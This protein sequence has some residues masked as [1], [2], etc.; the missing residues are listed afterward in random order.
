MKSRFYQQTFAGMILVCCSLMAQA[1]D[2]V[3][4][5]T[6]SEYA[7]PRNLPGVRHDADNAFQLAQKLGFDVKTATI[8]KDA[9]VTAQ[10]MRDAFKT[11]AEKVQRNDRVFVYFSGHGFSALKGNTCAQGIVSHDEALV[12]TRDLT[13][14]LHAVR[15]RMPSDALVI[16]DA[17]HSGGNRD[18]AVSGTRSVSKPVS[19]EV[20]AKV[21]T[22]KGGEYCHN[23]QN[24]LAANW[25]K[26]QTR[27]MSN[28]E[29]NF[30]FIAAANEREIALDDPN[31]GGVA[32]VGLLHCASQGA[33]DSNQSGTISYRE[34][35]NC[36][37]EFIKETVPKISKQFAP[38]QLEMFGNIDRTI[39]V[40]ATPVAAIPANAANQSA[41]LAGQVRGAFREIAAGANANW[42][43][44]AQF[45][46]EQVKLGSP[47]TLSYTSEY[48]GYAYVL[49]VGSDNHDIQQLYPDPGQHVLQP[50]SKTYRTLVGGSTATIS[51]PAGENTVL[52]MFSKVPLDMSAVLK[53]DSR[54]VSPQAL[55]A[56]Q[57]A[58]RG[59]NAPGVSGTAGVP[60]AS[61]SP[62]DG[63]VASVL[64][65]TGRN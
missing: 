30:T 15:D 64:A 25:V 20:R 48:P 35:G 14:M 5:M 41:H 53:G 63:Y 19:G 27:G 62:V 29:N 55:S 65:V 56:V 34:L 23:P 12:E 33:V 9:Q 10:G 49:Y 2:H 37:Q 4:I 1:A 39:P 7:P 11:L 51:E 50:A 57:R 43:F 6:I 47:V 45:D 38:H 28:P 13:G 58:T 40:I 32:T 44:D 16:F 54:P 46:H 21:W 18:M 60:T 31:K 59:L 26:P 42:G 17:C 36:T 52:V 24:I 61:S 22:P 8:L 3:L